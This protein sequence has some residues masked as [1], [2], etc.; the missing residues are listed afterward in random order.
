MSGPRPVMNPPRADSGDTLGRAATTA[1]GVYFIAVA[2]AL[3]YLLYLLWLSMPT[4]PKV[5]VPELKLILL[6]MIAGHSHWCFTSPCAVGSF[7]W[8]RTLAP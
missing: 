7:P 8:G 4:D 3:G 2:A 5:P 6:V 1:L